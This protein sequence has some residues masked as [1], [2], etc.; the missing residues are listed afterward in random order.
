MTTT[1]K[2]P[3]SIAG[4]NTFAPDPAVRIACA[5]DEFNVRTRHAVIKRRGDPHGPRKAQLYHTD[6]PLMERLCNWAD[7]H[8]YPDPE[9]KGPNRVPVMMLSNYAKDIIVMRRE[10]RRMV[11]LECECEAWRLK[12]RS[13]AEGDNLPWPPS[14]DAWD[15]E[16]YFLGEAT[17]HSYTDTLRTHGERSWT[18]HLP[19][20]TTRGT[21]NPARCS[22]ATGRDTKTG[23]P[24]KAGK[25][26]HPI[27]MLNFALGPWAAGE[28]AFVHAQSWSTVRAV[29]T[30]L[31]IVGRLTGGVFAGIAVDLVLDYTAPRPTPD[32]SLVRQPFWS[33]AVPYGMTDEEFRAEAIRRA[34]SLL[35]DQTELHRLLGLQQQLLTEGQSTWRAG[36]LLPEFR[37]EVAVALADDE[38]QYI[39]GQVLPFG[40]DE[41][42]AARRLTDEYGKA[43][44]MASA[45]V[46]AN[47]D[48]LAGMFARL[49]A[50][51]AAPEQ[52]WPE[53][54]GMDFDE[55]GDGEATR[56]RREGEAE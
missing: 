16:A 38:G 22:Y 24:T 26:C 19:A 20:G 50:R 51:A 53:G 9:G 15:R 52:E 31:A 11:P 49:P 28:I 6:E 13:E 12:T 55:T 5:T 4:S 18:V 23:L 2:H 48:D 32:G 39:E 8:G 14:A 41:E 47:R 1:T 43:P 25:A 37:P 29:R 3:L 7:D 46:Q 33:F 45:M 42:D 21:C 34:Q 27:T 35:G 56:L 17:R 54:R 30:S 36:A 10:M 40:D 44:D